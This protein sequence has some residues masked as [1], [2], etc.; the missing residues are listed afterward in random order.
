LTF[1]GAVIGN[2]LSIEG[3]AIRSEYQ[4]Q[5]LGTLALY[6]ILDSEDVQAAAS[7]TRNPAVPRLMANGFYTVSPDLNAPQ[8]LHHMMR[9]ARVQHVTEVYARHVGVDPADAPFAFG[10][11]AGGLYG[12]TDPGRCMPIPEIAGNPENGIIMVALDR[13]RAV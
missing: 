6:D 2:V 7:V 11:Y 1:C 13:M 9:D 10:R 5:G 4:H 8:P 12:S 3:R